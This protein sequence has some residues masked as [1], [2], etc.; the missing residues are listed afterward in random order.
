[1]HT[2]HIPTPVTQITHNL[3]LVMQQTPTPVGGQRQN[4]ATRHVDQPS[5]ATVPIRAIIL[6]RQ[7]PFRGDHSKLQ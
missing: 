6:P 2:T 4:P 7:V 5:Q 1:M 3:T